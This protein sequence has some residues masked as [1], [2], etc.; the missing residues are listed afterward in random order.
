MKIGG[1]RMGKS[2]VVPKASA[3]LVNLAKAYT[4][5]TAAVDKA[6]EELKK[7]KKI[8]TAAELKLADHMMTE[9]LQSFRADGLG[10]FRTKVEVY[11]S[12]KD[13]P[14]FEDFVRKNK[15]DFLFT[16]AIHGQ[17]FKSYVRELVENG[18]PVPTGVDTFMKTVI[19]RFK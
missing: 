5:A 1:A 6:D 3:V 17:K 2:A 9:G 14:L 10:G 16:T 8:Q 19:R 18:K 4:A 11:P 13:R 7:L 12:V 15:L